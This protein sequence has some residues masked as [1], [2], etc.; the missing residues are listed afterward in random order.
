MLL[1][2]PALAFAGYRFLRPRREHRGRSV[3]DT[4]LAIVGVGWFIGTWS[5]F[6]LQSALASRTS[7]IYYMVIV[8][9]GI[10][11]AVTY[12]VSLGWRR[13]NKAVYAVTLIWALSVLV[14]VVLMYPFVAAF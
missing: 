3:A 7:Y 1:A 4:Q 8:M 6:E 11:M 12:L 5:P 14:A 10:Y 9:P 13:R 2:L